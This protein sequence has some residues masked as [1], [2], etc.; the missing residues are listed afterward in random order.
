MRDIE[1]QKR[2]SLRTGR[3]DVVFQNAGLVGILLLLVSIPAIDVYRTWAGAR[4]EKQAWDV[5]GPPCPVVV[6]A[7]PSVVGHK[8]PRTFTYNK[9]RFTRH[10]GDVSCAAFREDG[11]MNPK[12]YSVCQ[13]SGPGAVTVEADGR[14]TTFQPGPGRRTTVTVHDGQASC[15]IAGWFARRPRGYKMTEP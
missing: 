14:R 2:R 9:V 4:A 1:A 13:F 7:D 12:S 5:Q 11:F 10:L 6:H 3:R 15:V 8:V